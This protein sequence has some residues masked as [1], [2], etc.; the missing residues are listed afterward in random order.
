MATSHVYAQGHHGNQ[1]V[2]CRPYEYGNPDLFYNF[3]VPPNCGGM[4]AAMYQA[5]QAV[6]PL[7]GQTYYTYQPLMPHEH[8]YEHNKLTVES[9]CRRLLARQ[10]IS[11]ST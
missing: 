1:M 3:Y 11:P 2:E 6:P 9:H 8:M 4:G 10:L 7:V 5:P